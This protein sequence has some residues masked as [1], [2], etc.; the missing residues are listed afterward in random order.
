ML[1]IIEIPRRDQRS[2]ECP[3]CGGDKCPVCN[4]LGVV[5]WN[6]KEDRNNGRYRKHTLVVR[7]LRKE[8]RECSEEEEDLLFEALRKAKADRDNDVVDSGQWVN[9]DG[10]PVVFN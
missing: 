7:A 2:K 5:F 10:W 9:A 1:N 6:S 3:S 4:Q 8:L